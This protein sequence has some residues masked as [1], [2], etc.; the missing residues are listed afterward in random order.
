MNHHLL[1]ID[2]S[3]RTDASRSRKLSAYYADAWRAAHPDGTVTY[4]DLA[5]DPLPH[6]DG[7]AFTA[8]FVPDEQ[9]TPEQRAARELTDVIVGEVLAADTIVIG[10][11]LYNFGVPSTVKA[12]FDRIVVPGVTLGD[13]GGTLGG[14]TLVFTTAA[15]GGYR[16][17]R[18]AR[19]G[20]TASRG[21]ATPL[22]SSGSPTRCSSAPSSRWRA[23]AQR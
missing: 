16:P 14:R 21:C 11:G 22:S 5:A 13:E 23:R 2:S 6:L 8:N 9:R 12:W 18:L 7:A 20:T 10:M 3:L 1:H 15:G 19:D 17:G 4:R